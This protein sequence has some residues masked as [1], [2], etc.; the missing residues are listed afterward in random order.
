MRSGSCCVSQNLIFCGQVTK[1]SSTPPTPL[2]MRQ[3]LPI[4]LIQIIGAFSMHLISPLAPFMVEDF[5]P[6]LDEGQ[7]GY[8]SGH[9]I[10]AYFAGQ[11]VASTLWGYLSDHFGRRP[12][13]LAGLL[14][15]AFSISG[16]ALSLSFWQALVARFMWGALNGNIGVVKTYLSE[17]L[18]DSNQAK[19]MAL[20]GT[21]FGFGQMLGPS[22]GGF[23]ARPATK[24]GF[25]AD[26]PLFV[27]F[28]YLLAC[29]VPVTLCCIGA[30][31]TYIFLPETHHKQDYGVLEE[32]KDG[33]SKPDLTNGEQ[34]QEVASNTGPKSEDPAPAPSSPSTLGP[35]PDGTGFCGVLTFRTMMP[36]SVYGFLGFI[37]IAYA[38]LFPLL[39]LNTVDEGGF[40][41]KTTEVGMV[42]ATTGPVQIVWGLPFAFPKLAKW[43]GYRRVLQTLPV[44]WALL[45]FAVPFVSAWPANDVQRFGI[46]SSVWIVASVLQVSCFTCVFV[47]I[48]NSCSKQTRG[49]VNGF[50]QSFVSLCRI[51]SPPLFGNVFAWTEGSTMPWPLDYHF[52]FH[53]LG[54]L[55]VLIAGW[56]LRLPACL[57]KQFQASPPTS[58][59]VPPSPT[60]EAQEMFNRVSVEQ[61][62]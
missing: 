18:D 38:T 55:A 33:P 40:G 21:C 26:V 44:L 3:M 13:L 41:Y 31:G 8:Y 27:K 47:L 16:F 37:F 24:W 23:L 7:L 5:Y 35:A 48:N 45:V 29:C 46:A 17:I 43:L 2:P 36:M 15:T 49:R 25:F 1:M 56:A 60:K 11:L 52:V 50:G 20:L 32:V 14:C 51:V 4:G 10:A 19:G 57:D 22:V 58:P 12:C 61:S 62:R 39:L 53:V 28:P 54:L 34:L 42:L 9:I 6:S 59:T 30:V